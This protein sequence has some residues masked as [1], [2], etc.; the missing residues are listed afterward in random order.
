MYHKYV[1]KL[2]SSRLRNSNW[3]LNLPLKTAISNKKDIISLSDSQI[4]RFIDDIN[5]IT[6]YNEKAQNIK[7]EI[8]NIKK[9]PKSKETKDRIKELY[10]DLYKLQFQKDYVCV[11]MDKLKDYDRA[12]QGFTINNIKYKR[13]LGTNGGIK[14]STIIYVNEEI[15]SKLKIKLDNGRNKEKEL[16]PAKLEAYQA[17]ICSGSTPVSFPKGVIVVSDCITNFK[18]AII[19]IDD[20]AEGEPVLTVE[21][22]KDCSLMDSDGYGLMLPSYSRRINGELTGDYESTVSGV[23]TRY[24]WNKG[25]LFTFDFVDF[26]DKISKNYLVTDAWGEKRDVREAEV[27]LTTSMLKL[28]DSYSSWEDY[29][30]NCVENGYQFSIAKATPNELENVRNM[31]YQ[32]LQ[33]YEFTPRE[34]YKICRPTIDEIKDVL[35][36]D[37]RKTL[38]FLKGMYLSDDN[39]ENVSVDFAK[40]LMIDKNMINDP[41]VRSQI[42]KMIHKRI[43]MA[44]KSSISVNAN[45][46]IVSG[47]PYSLCQHIFGLNVT[48]L[49]KANETYHKYWVDKGTKEIAV[50]RAPMT[51]HNNI[52]KLNVVS[53]ENMDY[54]YKYMNTC[55]ILNSWDTTCDAL[56]GEDKDS[57]GNFCTDNRILINNI[58]GLPAIQCVQRNASKIIPTEEDIILANKLSFGDEIGFTTNT[59][60]SQFEIQAGFPRDSKEYKTLDYRIMCGQLF[61]QNAI[62]KAKGIVAKP[63]PIEWHSDKHCL[64]KD[65]DSEIVKV[66]K[67]FNLKL[68]VTRKPYFMKYIYPQVNNQYNT[69][70]KHTNKKAIR[71]FGITIN[72]MINKNDKTEKEKEFIDYYYKFMP[73]GINPCTCNRIC[74]LFEKVFSDKCLIDDKSIIFDCSVLK[75]N[76]EYSKKDYQDI[77]K[78]YLKYISNVQ[79]FK[80]ISK[81]ERLEKDDITLQYDLLKDKFKA[82]CE[83]ICPNEDELCDIIVD[84][85]YTTNKSKQ[86]VWDICGDTIVNNLLKR[87]NYIINYPMQDS[88]GEF[89]YNGIKFKMVSKTIKED[90]DLSL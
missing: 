58:K 29:Y 11:I 28:W 59:I 65:G 18:A 73:V 2:H 21:S 53:D 70:I 24:A 62:D 9:L 33:S 89:K 77:N 16:V 15:Y 43:K 48:G 40:A 51:C 67:E 68:V 19:N 63:I 7:N 12:N 41:F 14:N 44:K 38:L 27:L 45:Y 36:M 37:Y 50:F 61:Q 3:K 78:I 42:Y 52:V 30:K 1:Y 87:N 22:N 55:Q 82:E 46:A 20:Q 74:W 79:D 17:L 25:M 34:L 31:N 13:F 10:E 69:Y 47:D 23:N 81:Q 76:S 57:D 49:L 84:M 60:T 4:L 35:G 83:M 64:P 88:N 66:K 32:F 54:W 85:C 8:K 86:F 72:D 75:S 56:N 71:R 26:A 80:Y 5:G 6:G 39:V 90:D